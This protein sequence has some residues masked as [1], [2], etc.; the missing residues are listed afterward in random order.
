MARLRTERM[1]IPSAGDESGFPWSIQGLIRPIESAPEHH[2]LAYM[3]A[4]LYQTSLLFRSSHQGRLHTRRRHHEIGNARHDFGFEAR[5]V[6]HAV[7]SD[8]L[9]H[10]MHPEIVGNCA[11]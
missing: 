3:R 10:V 11:A 6:E 5:S 8:A 7:M 9:L 4:R 2:D 1:L